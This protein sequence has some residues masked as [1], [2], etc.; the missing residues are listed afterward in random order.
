VRGENP[1]Q[2]GASISQ[3]KASPH[4]PPPSPLGG[5]GKTG[6]AVAPPP[7]FP[8]P[9]SPPGL[10]QPFLGAPPP[11]PPPSRRGGGGPPKPPVPQPLA[12]LGRGE[13]AVAVVALAAHFASAPSLQVLRKQLLGEPPP[14]PAPSG[15]WWGVPESQR[16]PGHYLE[17]VTLAAE[18]FRIPPREIEE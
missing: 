13:K 14:N 10:R 5:G 4:P 3:E 1:P 15:R 6:A 18:R 7:P 2:R 9:P 12:P 8:S 17:E 16:F 11:H